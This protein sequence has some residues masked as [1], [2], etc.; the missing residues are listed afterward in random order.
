MAGV[1]SEAFLS[2][3]DDL[4]LL[5]L[6]DG[7]LLV[8]ARRRGAARRR[9]RRLWRRRSAAVRTWRLRRTSRAFAA[10]L[11]APP[12][13]LDVLASLPPLLKKIVSVDAFFLSS[14][15]ACVVG[16]CT[17]GK[18]SLSAF[19]QYRGLWVSGVVL[20]PRNNGS[21]TLTYSSQYVLYDYVGCAAAGALK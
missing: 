4:M 18:S 8:A 9:L 14:G 15:R 7:L 6:I 16:A 21:L 13:A 12:G 20:G 10:A 1:F 3:L 2:V 11:A 5:A 17:D 19:Q